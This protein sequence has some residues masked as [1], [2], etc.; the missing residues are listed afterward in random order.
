MADRKRTLRKDSWEGICRR[1]LRWMERV[2]SDMGRKMHLDMSFETMIPFF[3][4]SY[5]G[6][7]VCWVAWI[8]A[9]SSDFGPGRH[10]AGAE[11]CSRWS[12]AR[13]L[14][15]DLQGWDFNDDRPL[16]SPESGETKKEMDL[17]ISTRGF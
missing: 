12:A 15:R 9:Y 17:W 6:G 11:G 16:Y 13:K 7:K 3:H 14:A 5:F 8:D 10:L 1:Y 4:P 2:Y